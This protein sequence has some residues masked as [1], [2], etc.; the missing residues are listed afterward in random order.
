MAHWCFHRV[1]YTYQVRFRYSW[2]DATTT[3]LSLIGHTLLTL[4]V[5]HCWIFWIVS[6]ALKAYLQ[7]Q[8]GIPYHSLLHVMYLSLAVLG[9]YRWKKILANDALAHPVTPESGKYQPN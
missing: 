1:I 5:I 3:I 8:Q 6:D 9:Y 7:Y 2:W 4:K